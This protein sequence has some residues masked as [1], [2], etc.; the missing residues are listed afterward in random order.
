MVLVWSDNSIALKGLWTQLL[1]PHSLWSNRCAIVGHKIT[2]GG[3]GRSNGVNC[4]ESQMDLRFVAGKLHKMMKIDQAE[5]AW[6]KPDEEIILHR[7]EREMSLKFLTYEVRLPQHGKINEE[8]EIGTNFLLW[9][10]LEFTLRGWQFLEIHVDSLNNFWFLDF[11]IIGRCI[12]DW[13]RT[14]FVTDDCLVKT[15]NFSMDSI[16]YPVQSTISPY[17]RHL[18]IFDR[19]V[20]LFWTSFW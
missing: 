17:P 9:D 20:G 11:K 14:K 4:D 15:K 19:S 5:G 13:Y 3:G 18:S 2:K 6:E 8:G 1:Q 10:L 16:I 7:I 12:Y